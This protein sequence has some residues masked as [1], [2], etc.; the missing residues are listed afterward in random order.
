MSEQ[1]MID[2]LTGLENRMRELEK[3]TKPKVSREFVEKWAKQLKW[4][5]NNYEDRKEELCA[6]LR[7]AGVEVKG[8]AEEEK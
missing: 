5:T 6:M 8:K 4:F 2:R 3:Q 7:E 1:G